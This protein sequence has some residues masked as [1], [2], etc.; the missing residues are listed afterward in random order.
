MQRDRQRLY[1]LL[2][3]ARPTRANGNY[4]YIV[5]YRFPSGVARM[6]PPRRGLRQLERRKNRGPTR[7]GTETRRPCTADHAGSS[8]AN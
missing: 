4:T 6:R 8:R 3:G 5:A 2:G 7:D 1:V